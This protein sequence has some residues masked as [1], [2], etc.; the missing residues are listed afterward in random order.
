M[1]EILR[2]PAQDDCYNEA[3]LRCIIP[4]AFSGDALRLKPLIFL[5]LPNHDLRIEVGVVGVE[6]RQSGTRAFIG[7]GKVEKY[8]RKGSVD[9]GFTGCPVRHDQSGSLKDARTRQ[10][11]RWLNW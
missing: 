6:G 9:V 4:S 2:L 3:R 8:Q 10:G 11:S 1:G 7:G 5:T